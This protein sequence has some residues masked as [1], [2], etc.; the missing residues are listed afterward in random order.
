MDPDF[1]KINHFIYSKID[2]YNKHFDNF[3]KNLNI[4]DNK[5]RTVCKNKVNETIKKNPKLHLTN[6]IKY[7]VQN[8]EEVT[9]K[10]F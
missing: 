3:Q 6:Q 7:C 9:L 1:D 8:L 5:I 2:N 4:Q 10:V